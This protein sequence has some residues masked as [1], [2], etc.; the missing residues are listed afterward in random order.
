MALV[1][2]TVFASTFIRKVNS[3]AVNTAFEGVMPSIYGN[4]VAFLAAPPIS[5]GSGVAE[6]VYFDITAPGA[7]LPT[8]AMGDIT[9]LSYFN[10]AGHGPSV[11]DSGGTR[12]IA[13]HL[14][15]GGL[16]LISYFD[17]ATLTLVNTGAVG[18]GASVFGNRIAF[19]T[20][21]GSIGV[22]LNGDGDLTD[23]VIRYWD[24]TG[25]F[26]VNTMVEG[27]R[28]SLYGDVIAF[29]TYEGEVG[30]LPGVNLN[31]GEAG[32]ADTTDY[33]IRYYNIA[34][35]TLMNTGRAGNYP[36][37]HREII[38]FETSEQEVGNLPGTDL[39]IPP[40]GD[41]SDRIIR[42]YNI[43]GA[44]AGILVNTGKD[45]RIPSVSDTLIA[46][47]TYEGTLT[48]APMDLNGDG[49]TADNVIRYYDAAQGRFTSDGTG[50]AP[51]AAAAGEFAS[52]Y[53]MTNGLT[54]QRTIVFVTHEGWVG[55][56]MDL[57]GDGDTLD[58]VIRFLQV[59]MNGDINGDG[60]VFD[61][62]P[63]PTP[64]LDFAEFLPYWGTAGPNPLWN[65]AADLNGDGL[66]NIADAGLFGPLY[67]TPGPLGDLNSDGIVDRFDSYILQSV[68]GLGG[69]ANFSPFADINDDGMVNIIDAATIGMQWLNTLEDPPPPIIVPLGA[70]TPT[71]SV[72]PSYTIA[73]YGMPVTLNISI[74]DAT[75][76][77]AWQVGL[78]YNSSVLQVLSVGEGEL[79]KGKGVPT[80][81]AEGKANNTAGTLAF[82]GNSLT[83]LGSGVN[84]SGQL[85]TVAFNVTAHGETNIQLVDG[86]LLN[87]T[88]GQID[89]VFQDGTVK[90]AMVGDVAGV[91]VFP[92]TSPDGKVDIKDIAAIAKCY[93][94][95]YP[96]PQYVAKYDITGTT[97]EVPDGK[98]DIKDLA[99]AAKNYGKTD[100]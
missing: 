33:V 52:V 8:G 77:Y 18:Q 16:P 36:S 73:R 54:G 35:A 34:T 14:R 3:A 17:I 28:P 60:V 38:A 99:T 6:V 2:S 32:D 4:T 59:Q 98:I 63:V 87:S 79:L 49:D 91:G 78:T 13:F 68:F 11:Y 53:G 29:E 5:P 100:P 64:G 69:N 23:N 74:S 25:G 66:V 70:T 24:I 89:A 56:G 26:V 19:Y 65:P 43:P 80:L 48:P 84:G 67:G 50:P 7:L 39:S 88:L 94:A 72:S 58:Y 55:T 95:I 37:L 44:G 97:F 42:Y 82:S 21:E 51:A 31:P 76:L 75:D 93:G 57:N 22:D 9:W 61:T 20:N 45:G 47:D 41:M 90:V 85:M 10:M 15:V 96:S 1:L 62:L 27:R 71:I 83:G 92:N 81:W 46:F 86:I 12:Y 30:L 40:D